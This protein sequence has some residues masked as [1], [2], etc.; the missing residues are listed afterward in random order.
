MRDSFK[1]YSGVRHEKQKITRYRRVWMR[2]GGG[3][4]GG[5]MSVV[6]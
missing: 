2:G 6:S 3:G 4:G 5:Q 1:I